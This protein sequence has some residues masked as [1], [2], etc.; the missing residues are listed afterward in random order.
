[1]NET[2]IMYVATANKSMYF[3]SIYA[4]ITCPSLAPPVNAIITYAIDTTA[5]FNYQTTATYS[6]TG[7]YGLSGED[8]SRMCIFSSTSVGG[9][10]WNKVQ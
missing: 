7:G 3:A 5:P 6:C 10:D 4:V 9:G 8:V 1:M 2:I